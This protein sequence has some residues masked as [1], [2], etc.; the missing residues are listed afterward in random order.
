MIAV[1][2]F[3]GV[4]AE[5]PLLINRFM[6]TVLLWK[7]GIVFYSLGSWKIRWGVLL[8]WD[9]HLPVRQPNIVG[10]RNHHLRITESWVCALR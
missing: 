5:M 1:K 10:N 4:K 6:Y 7:S 8:I 9:R 3:N 2:N